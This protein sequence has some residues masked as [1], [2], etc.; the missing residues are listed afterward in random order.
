MLTTVCAAVILA[1]AL[2]TDLRTM[3]IPNKLTL[4]ALL[5]GLLY[6]LAIDGIAGG[7]QA[8]LGAIA[9]AGPLLIVYMLGGIGA[10]DVKLFAA[11]GAWM[12]AAWI[13]EML[14]YAILYAGAVGL[15]LLAMRGRFARRFI[16]WMLM[17]F[18][19]SRWSDKL[20]Q[21]KQLSL[22]GLKF[23]FMIAAVPGA[24]TV[25]MMAGS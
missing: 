21:M 14:M 8:L 2:I 23:P 25:W 7:G 18:I 15:A 13:L 3:L 16:S 5:A 19:P 20:G 6:H 22:S 17:L 9:G 11:L 12:G 24:V 10:G 4:P 1:Y